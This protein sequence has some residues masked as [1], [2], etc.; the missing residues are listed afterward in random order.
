MRSQDN[1]DCWKSVHL[2]AY[3]NWLTALMH[4]SFTKKLKLMRSVTKELHFFMDK[5]RVYCETESSMHS[6]DNQDCLKSVH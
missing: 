2:Y 4:L 5:A 3:K 1:Q 6:Q